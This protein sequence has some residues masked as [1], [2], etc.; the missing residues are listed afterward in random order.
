[1]T[2]TWS[3]TREFFLFQRDRCNDSA[4]VLASRILNVNEWAGRNR[5]K[6]SAQQSKAVDECLRELR[7]QLQIAQ[8]NAT[9][10]SQCACLLL[11]AFDAERTP[12]QPTQEENSCNASCTE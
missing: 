8:N 7:R 10:Y 6:F 9:A 5:D 3:F 12:C 11:V 2:A 1:M 4:D